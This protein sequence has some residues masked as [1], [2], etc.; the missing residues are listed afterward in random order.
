MA[1]DAVIL[2]HDGPLDLHSTLLSGQAFRWR[3]GDGWFR[4]VVSGKAVRLRGTPE[5]VGIRR[6]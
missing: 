3:A 6:R 2:P 1:A 5:G 4:G